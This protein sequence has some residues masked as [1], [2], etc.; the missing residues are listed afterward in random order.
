M[1]V[2]IKNIMLHICGVYFFMLTLSFLIYAS[3]TN[4]QKHGW[5]HLAFN[6]TY[7]ESGA[8]L[9]T[10]SSHQIYPRLL[11]IIHNFARYFVHDSMYNDLHVK[12]GY[13]KAKCYKKYI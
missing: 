8:R 4:T 5:I 3:H 10:E 9:I 6:R 1:F 13:M 12:K 7:Y 2:S 11:L